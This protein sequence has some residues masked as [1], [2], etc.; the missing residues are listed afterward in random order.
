[1]KGIDMPMTPLRELFLQRYE[2]LLR[3]RKVS[4]HEL[5]CRQ[6]AMEVLLNLWRHP[7]R[8]QSYLRSMIRQIG[9]LI[10]DHLALGLAGA[11]NAHIHNWDVPGHVAGSSLRFSV[12]EDAV[13]GAC[14]PPRILDMLPSQ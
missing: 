6:A 2:A 7:S 8:Q 12:I 4:R 14:M 1:M 11:G 5:G 3:L 13:P 10:N 9:N